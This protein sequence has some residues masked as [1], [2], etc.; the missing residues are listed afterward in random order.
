MS[1]HSL[2][3]IFPPD[4]VWH[5]PSFLL[6]PVSRP[7]PTIFPTGPVMVSALADWF[8]L[9]EPFP[10]ARL[11]HRPDDGGSKDLWNVGELLPDYT[12]LQPRRQ[13]SLLSWLRHLNLCRKNKLIFVYFNFLFKIKTTF[14][15]K[16]WSV[17]TK[18]QR[19]YVRRVWDQCPVWRCADSVRFTDHVSRQLSASANVWPVPVS[20]TS[21]SKVVCFE[22]TCSFW[23]SSHST[24]VSAS[25]TLIS[26][27]NTN[28]GRLVVCAKE[29]WEVVCECVC[30]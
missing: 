23:Q 5:A 10:R 1:N 25:I 3:V 6:A 7:I 15:H 9:L 11:T 4:H 16:H 17:W 13:P 27:G 21:W 29:W 2:A 20:A 8:P 19:H 28:T 12:A 18:I 30:C 24:N 22:T 26:T 14:L